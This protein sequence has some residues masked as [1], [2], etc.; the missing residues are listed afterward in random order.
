MTQICVVGVYVRD[1]DAAREF[2]CDKLGFEVVAEYGDCILQMKHE[3]IVF[4]V[5]EIQ[6]DFPEEPCTVIAT[7]TD[8]LE[9]EMDRL[10]GLGVTFIHDTP[11]PFPAG[12]FAAYR[13]PSGNLLELIE[14][15]EE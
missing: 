1:I 14:F 8:N 15:R 12:M 6:G 11:Q 10:R 2:Y 3:G 7:P 13:D 4:V 5:E 9:A